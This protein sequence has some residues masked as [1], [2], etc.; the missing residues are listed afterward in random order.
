M[1]EEFVSLIQS[2]VGQI[3]DVLG[4]HCI[5][6]RV[7]SHTMHMIN[8]SVFDDGEVLEFWLTEDITHVVASNS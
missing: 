5:L 6:L 8:V 7:G 1:S 3:I 2:S 4:H